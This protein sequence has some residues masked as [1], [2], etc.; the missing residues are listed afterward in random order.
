MSFNTII[1]IPFPYKGKGR[2]TSAY[3]GIMKYTSG[4]TQATLRVISD[5]DDFSF[6]TIYEALY[7]YVTTTLGLTVDL[8]GTI[9]FKETGVTIRIKNE[10]ISSKTLR[11]QNVG[12]SNLSFDTI[13]DTF[14]EEVNDFVKAIEDAIKNPA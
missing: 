6:P 3:S 2:E 14:E 1:I 9:V 13:S 12:L 10:P 11:S 7:K 5:R 8:L 4:K